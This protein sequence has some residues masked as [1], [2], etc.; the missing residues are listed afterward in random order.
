MSSLI[1][2]YMPVVWEIQRI[3]NLPM[4]TRGAAALALLKT[5]A[6]E[7]LQEAATEARVFFWEDIVAKARQIEAGPPAAEIPVEA[8]EA[9]QGETLTVEELSALPRQ[10][11][12]LIIRAMYRKYVLNSMEVNN[13]ILGSVWLGFVGHIHRAFDPDTLCYNRKTEFFWYTR[14]IRSIRTGLLLNRLF[15]DAQA[16]WDYDGPPRGSPVWTEILEGNTATT[17]V[18]LDAAEARA[19]EIAAQ[20]DAA[21]ASS[22]FRG[23][24]GDA[25]CEAMALSAIEPSRLELIYQIATNLQGHEEDE[26][27]YERCERRYGRCD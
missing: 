7:Y 15:N 17:K 9:L 4:L 16:L 2:T 19:P 13:G 27:Y 14:D 26:D 8:A 24:L 21:I 12:V 1:S 5:Y 18:A 22:I 20:S 6:P 11:I 23:L 10:E 25:E 3:R